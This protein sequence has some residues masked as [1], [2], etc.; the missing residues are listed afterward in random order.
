MRFAKSLHSP[1]CVLVFLWLACFCHGALSCPTLCKCY[2]R[3]NEVVCNEV[4]LTEFPSEG[5]PENTT[6]LTIQFTNITSI[7]KE[8]LNAIPMLQGLHLYSN[9]LHS[10]PSHLLRGVPHLNTLDLTGNNHAPL[11]SLVLKNNLIK[12]ADAE[13]LSDNKV[14]ST[15]HIP[16]GLLD[17]LRSLDADG[18]DL[19]VNPWLCDEK[20][21]Y[22][23]RWL[24]N[25]KKK[26]FMPETIA[27]AGPQ[28]LAGRSVMSLTA[29]ELNLHVFLV[30]CHLFLHCLD[31]VQPTGWR[32]ILN[33]F[34]A[35]RAEQ[36]AQLIYSVYPSQ[37]HV[38]LNAFTNIFSLY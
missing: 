11:Q 21:E 38:K 36:A 8:H 17:H 29:N 23:W 9:Q 30:I 32:K 31:T 25:N 3:R 35:Q 5:L 19:T 33:Q 10:L 34:S 37:K 27:C 2:P 22:L 13:W 26:V 18:L 15:F 24:Q 20:V 4:P 12:K 14:P 6:L 16:P 7:S 1:C 28:A